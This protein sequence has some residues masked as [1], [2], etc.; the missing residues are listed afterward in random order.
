MAGEIYGS[1]PQHFSPALPFSLNARCAPDARWG[2]K[3]QNAILSSFITAISRTND[4]FRCVIKATTE[5]DSSG[6]GSDVEGDGG[7]R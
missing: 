4:G 1:S 7:G 5:G 3:K 2:L 6:E